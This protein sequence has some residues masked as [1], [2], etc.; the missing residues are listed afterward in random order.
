VRPTSTNL[1][2]TTGPRTVSKDEYYNSP[3]ARLNT[4]L[5]DHKKFFELLR[6]LRPEYEKD[7]GPMPGFSAWVLDQ[8][9]IKLYLNSDGR[10]T[11]DYTIVDQHKYLIC[12]LKYSVD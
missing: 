10:I 1:D 8:Y 3:D 11:A 4:V 9:G 7:P 12:R 5:G 6:R 2:Q